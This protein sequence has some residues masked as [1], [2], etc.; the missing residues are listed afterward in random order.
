MADREAGINTAL[1][2]L[3][4]VLLTL[5]L[6]LAGKRLPADTVEDLK[7][8]VAAAEAAEDA[9]AEAAAGDWS[10]VPSSL[11]EYSYSIYK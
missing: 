1:T 6:L 3:L 8:R 10:P 5:A 2:S 9:A 4:Q 11:V 7:K